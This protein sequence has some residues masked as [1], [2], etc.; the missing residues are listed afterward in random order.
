M[1]NL[2]KS[3][4]LSLDAGRAVPSVERLLS[5]IWAWEPLAI[6]SDPHRSP[7][8]HKAVSGRARVVERARGGGES[9]HRTSRRSAACY[10]I[11]T[12]GLLRSPVLCSGR[13]GRKRTWLSAMTD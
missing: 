12:L 1:P 9:L 11:L 3:G 5:R 10:W 6:V 4:G 2:V 13:L 8:L 7:E